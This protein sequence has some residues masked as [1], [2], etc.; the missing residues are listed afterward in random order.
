[1]I[2]AV[3]VLPARQ[4]GRHPV[5][6]VAS[7][8]AV[9]S[10]IA[11]G[12]SLAS[13]CALDETGPASAQVTAWMSTAA[14]GAAIGQVE[15][16]SRNV[17]L[18]LSRHDPPSAMRTVCALLTNDAQTAI[19]NLPTPDSR[20]TDELNTAYEDAAAAGNDCYNGANGSASLLRRSAEERARLVRLLDT[21]V[22]RI[23]SVTGQTPS[24]STTAPSD[25]GD[26]PFAN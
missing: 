4:P 15:V 21:A 7:G 26:D 13:G 22:E 23:A 25:V 16:D 17:D 2:E 1:M 3:P 10:L 6:V 14:G 12:S 5:R 9:V 20:L 19:G 8:L 18:A 24:T 11:L